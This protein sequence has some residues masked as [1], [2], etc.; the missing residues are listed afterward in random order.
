M[1][2]L[3]KDDPVLK[4]IRTSFNANP[5]RVPEERIQPLV[6]FGISGDKNIYLGSVVNVLLGEDKPT[7]E[8]FKSQLPNVSSARTKS[9][10]ADVGVKIMDGFLEGLGSNSAGLS[11]T[12]KTAK[13]VSFTFQNVIRNYVDVAAAMKV[14]GRHKVDTANAVVQSFI[15]GHMDCVLVTGIIGSDNFTIKVEDESSHDFKLDI[16]KIESLISSKKNK[17]K[18]SSSGKHDISFKGDRHLAFAFEAVKLIFSDDGGLDLD[19]EP[20]KMFLTTSPEDKDDVRDMPVFLEEEGVLVD[21]T[22]EEPMT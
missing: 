21:I 22:F 12:F 6:M 7:I 14:L 17:V 3:C 8:I 18:V 5:I 4:L 10:S 15:N 20:D 9:V 1:I 13:K 19:N 11:D 2:K 16:P